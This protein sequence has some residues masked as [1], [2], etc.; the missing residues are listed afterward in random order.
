MM[1]GPVK[2]FM[3]GESEAS[4]LREKLVSVMSQSYFDWSTLYTPAPATPVPFTT[5]IRAEDILKSPQKMRDVLTKN[6]EKITELRPFQKKALDALILDKQNV[7]VQNYTGSGKSL[8]FQMYALLHAGLTVVVSPFVAITLGRCFSLIADQIQKSPL[9]V[10]TVAINSWLSFPQRDHFLQIISEGSVKLLFI[11]PELFTSYFIP[12]FLENCSVI[13][14][15]MICVDEAH[16]ACLASTDYRA[17]YSLIPHCIEVITRTQQSMALDKNAFRVPNANAD[18]VLHNLNSVPPRPRI[19]LLTATANAH[20]NRNICAKFQIG[21]YFPPE[22]IF[23]RNF[24]LSFKRVVNPNSALLNIVRGKFGCKFPVIVF[25]SFKRSTETLT[26]YLQQNGFKAYCFHG[27]LSELQ[28]MNTLKELD[29]LERTED[30]SAAGT[31]SAKD[32]I[33]RLFQVDLIVS[34][35][36]LSMGLDCSRLNGVLHFNLPPSIESYV[37][38]IGRSGRSGQDSTCVT[39]LKKADFYF[40]R[41]KSLLEFY[42]PGVVLDCVVDLLCLDKKSFER[43]MSLRSRNGSKTAGAEKVTFRAKQ[44]YFTIKEDEPKKHLNLD[45]RAFHYLLNLLRENCSFA[46]EVVYTLCVTAKITFRSKSDSLQFLLKDPQFQQ[47]QNFG[48]KIKNGVSFNVNSV[49]NAMN[50]DPLTVIARLNRLARKFHGFLIKTGYAVYVQ[51]GDSEVP[52]EMADMRQE[53]KRVLKESVQHN[54]KRRLRR[55]DLFYFILDEA[56]KRFSSET[57]TDERSRFIQSQ[58]E[59]Y[60]QMDELEFVDKQIGWDTLKNSLPLEFLPVGSGNQAA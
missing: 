50:W 54:L 45:K 10:P 4:S 34:T 6:F 21:V 39:F 14:I 18:L 7:F 37:Q 48:K 25:C 13:R 41:N 31:Q 56:L 46:L 22:K 28:K 23:Q 8:L 35:V 33:R 20:V 55:L 30:K 5:Q 12:F 29:K 49:A 9:N 42:Q 57:Q 59:K 2:L 60:F 47:I 52:T 32:K 27:G 53:M 44:K 58:I 3:L 1:N 19:L 17:S 16:S 51:F 40:S 15:N 11:T 38:Q 43:R 36:G 24:S 26:V